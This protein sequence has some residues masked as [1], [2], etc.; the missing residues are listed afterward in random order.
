MKKKALLLVLA[1]QTI[2]E[3]NHPSVARIFQSCILN[4]HLD[5]QNLLD[6]AF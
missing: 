3:E 1:E 5:I 2:L 6:N 4:K